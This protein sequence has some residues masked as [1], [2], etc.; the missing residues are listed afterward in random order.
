MQKIIEFET[1]HQAQ[2]SALLCAFWQHIVFLQL[3][4]RRFRFEILKETEE[5]DAQDAGEE[6]TH[7]QGQAPDAEEDGLDQQK[8][9]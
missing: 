2:N 5:E 7:V 4:G 6:V 8:E 3:L 1:V 9:R